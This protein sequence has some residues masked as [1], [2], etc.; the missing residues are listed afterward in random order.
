MRARTVETTAFWYSPNSVRT[1]PGI[2]R[3]TFCNTII[4]QAIVP[5]A[6]RTGIEGGL[7]E[8]TVFS[9]DGSLEEFTG[10]PI[11]TGTDWVHPMVERTEERQ[12]IDRGIH[13]ARCASGC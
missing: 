6:D 3:F 12:P 5:L 4:W 10:A 1:Q 7:P 8:T 2:R 13:C 11:S 9:T